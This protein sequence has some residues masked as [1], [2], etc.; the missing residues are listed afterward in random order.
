MT[1]L[2]IGYASAAP[3]APLMLATLH[4]DGIDPRDYWISEKLDGVRGRWDG[5]RLWSRG[6]QRIAVPD[7]FVEGWPAI[8]MDGEL[9]I[10]RG[11]FE[12]VSALVRSVAPEDAAWRGVRLM[13]FDLPAHGGDFSERVAAMQALVRETDSAQLAMVEQSRV[14]ESSAVDARLR[15]VIAAG[16]EGLMLHHAEAHYRD[17]RSDALLKLKQAEDAEGIVIGHTPGQ[18]KYRGLTG[19]LVVRLENGRTLRLGSGLSDIERA[20]PPAIG[21]RVTFRY[22]GLTST[23][24]PRF[25]RFL[26]VR[27]D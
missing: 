4:H 3:K 2:A 15:R 10:A 5:Q 18:G 8:P 26:R 22:N 16:G 1:A 7:W 20:Q 17:G 14:E 25:A 13:I 6:G 12:T 21:S 24:L 19:A 9:W 11:E 23:G 27:H